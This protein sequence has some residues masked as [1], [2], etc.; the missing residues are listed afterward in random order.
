MMNWM[1]LRAVDDA[2]GFK[3]ELAGKTSARL[4]WPVA[5]SHFGDSGS[6]LRAQ[7]G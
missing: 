6:H 7:P 1:M 4:S 5:T 2:K 3:R